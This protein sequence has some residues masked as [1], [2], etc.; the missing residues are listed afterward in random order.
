MVSSANVMLAFDSQRAVFGSVSS[1]VRE[2][3]IPPLTHSG[4]GL[5]CG[6]DEAQSLLTRFAAPMTFTPILASD[7]TGAILLPLAILFWGGTGGGALAGL[8][9]LVLYRCKRVQQVWGLLLG[10]L[11]MVAGAGGSFVLILFTD[12]RQFWVWVSVL[13]ALAVGILDV[14]LWKSR[15]DER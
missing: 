2:S 13:T 8:L 10:T 9:A 12:G 15:K 11:S 14:I 7:M 3:P 6:K 1:R 5:P 4:C